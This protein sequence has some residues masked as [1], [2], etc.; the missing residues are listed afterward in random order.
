MKPERDEAHCQHD[1]HGFDQHIDE[2]ADGFGHRHRL[3]LNLGKLHAG[4]QLP[5]DLVGRDLQRLAQRDDVA[6][7]G[8]RDAECHHFLALVVHLDC[9]RVYIAAMNVRNVAQPQ[10]VARAPANRHVAQLFDTGELARH[11]HLHHIQRRLDRAGRLDRVLRADLRQYR[12]EVE[13][14]L[15]HALL[16]YLDEHLF[17][18]QTELLHLGNVFHPQQALAHI[19][20]EG[21]E[22]GLAEAFAF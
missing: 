2:L 8:H 12:I 19:V 17:V 21:L 10:L 14:Q 3:V 22:L 7:L 11:P 1:G 15:R 6:A 16:R 5:V 13:P 18:L 4:R 20:G 9:R